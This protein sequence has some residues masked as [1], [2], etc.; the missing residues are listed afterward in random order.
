MS[1]AFDPWWYDGV[2]NDAA[3]PEAQVRLFARWIDEGKSA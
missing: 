3:R 2:S 1:F